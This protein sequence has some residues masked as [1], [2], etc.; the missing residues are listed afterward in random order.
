MIEPSLSLAFFV[1]NASCLAFVSW[2]VP[3]EFQ[4]SNNHITIHNPFMVLGTHLQF[5]ISSLMHIQ[6]KILFA[7]C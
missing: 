2:H 4:S 6:Q 5:T 3:G 7:A 1:L